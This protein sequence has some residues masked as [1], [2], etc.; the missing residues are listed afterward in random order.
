M[1]SASRP[2]RERRSCRRRGRRASEKRL[3][4]PG[5]DSFGPQNKLKVE[6][7]FQR[8]HR[9]IGENAVGLNEEI[10]HL[11]LPALVY[12][13]L[14]H[15]RPCLLEVLSLQV[16]DQQAVVPQKQRVVAPSRFTQGRLHLRPNLTMA[17]PVLRK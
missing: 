11:A 2:C 3:P 7:F 15:A 14:R 1:P 6:D 9:A 17:L 4:V 8:A 13:F 10:P 16:S 5:L 12:F